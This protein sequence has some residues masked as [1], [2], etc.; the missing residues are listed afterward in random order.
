MTL[1]WVAPQNEY[2]IEFFTVNPLTGNGETRLRVRFPDPTQGPGLPA[3]FLRL[4][5]APALL[6]SLLGTGLSR[7]EGLQAEV[8]M[9]LQSPT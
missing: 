5:P 1:S 3:D 7:G 6:C 8:F 2:K 9:F 4:T